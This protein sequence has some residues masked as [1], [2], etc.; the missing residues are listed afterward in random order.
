MDFLEN[1]IEKKRIEGKI[2]ELKSEIKELKQLISE[3]K[4]YRTAIEV[5]T[6]NWVLEKNSFDRI[7]LKSVQLVSYFEGVSA[8][9][10]KG[11]LLPTITDINS[12]NATM[13]SICSAIPAQI[14]LIN[15]RITELEKEIEGL[16]AELAALG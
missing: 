7:I 11:R 8:E 3:Y 15:D 14:T 9:N 5:K 10:I 16:E 6:A 12:A 1:F 4:E 13:I 2:R